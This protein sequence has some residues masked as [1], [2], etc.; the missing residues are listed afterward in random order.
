M[1]LIKVASDIR[2]KRTWQLFQ[3]EQYIPEY[4]FFVT[5]RT[6]EPGAQSKQGVSEKYAREKL[7]GY[8]PRHTDCIFYARVQTN[9]GTL[10]ALCVHVNSKVHLL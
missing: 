1:S 2:W 4:H 6:V 10:R 5:P 8:S 7:G 9:N 3:K